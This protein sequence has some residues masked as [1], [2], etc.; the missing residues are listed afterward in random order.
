MAVSAITATSFT[1]CSALPICT[2]FALG[3]QN[4]VQ[5]QLNF[6]C[7]VNALKFYWKRSRNST[8][9]SLRWR[10]HTWRSHRKPKQATPKSLVVFYVTESL[11]PWFEAPNGEQNVNAVQG[12]CRANCCTSGYGARNGCIYKIARTLQFTFD[13][14][15]NYWSLQFSMH[16]RRPSIFDSHR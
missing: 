7:N 13:G 1:N 6:K 15:P 4:S 10:I 12:V 14:L 2:Y 3:L 8:R 9:S 16:L 5:T 11:P